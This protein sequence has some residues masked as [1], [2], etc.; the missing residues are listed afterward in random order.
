MY[1]ELLDIPDLRIRQL[2]TEKILDGSV[3]SRD[4]IKRFKSAFMSIPK[5]LFSLF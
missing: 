3:K 5:S 2:L 4:E 1:R